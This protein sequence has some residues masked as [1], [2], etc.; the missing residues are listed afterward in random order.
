MVDYE[1]HPSNDTSHIVIAFAGGPQNVYQ[2][3][4]VLTAWGGYFILMR[5]STQKYHNQGVAGIGDREAVV[6]YIRRLE[7]WPGRRITTIGVSSGAY[8]ALLYGQLVPADEVI[9]ISAI[10]SRQE[11]GF[12]PADYP[13]IVDP[14]NPDVELLPYFKEGPIPRVRAF[15][16]DGAD[17]RL[18]RMMIERI[19]VK[20]VTVVPGYSHG[21]LARGMR[22]RG[23]FK[24]L[25]K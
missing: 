18:D 3:R 13:F 23:M 6:N 21:E 8:A 11:D 7:A 25:L 16:S 5:D 12:D 17:T 14:A 2:F 22:D 4:N 1:E 19:G 15:I 9:A 20:D 24:E 10:T